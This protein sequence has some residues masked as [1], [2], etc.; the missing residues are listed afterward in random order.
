MYEY[1]TPESI[2]EMDDTML[3]MNLNY[4]WKNFC[5][6]DTYEPGS[7]MVTLKPCPKE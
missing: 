6:S 2:A 7:I 4:L 5:I 3:Y 1:V